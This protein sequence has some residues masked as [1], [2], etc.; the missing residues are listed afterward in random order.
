MA[1]Y[2]FLY[3]NNESEKRMLTSELYIRTVACW[4]GMRAQDRVV[5]LQFAILLGHQV[6]FVAASRCVGGQL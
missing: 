4:D 1:E 6:L 2:W 3:T 5:H